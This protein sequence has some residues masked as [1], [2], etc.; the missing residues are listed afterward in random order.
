MTVYIVMYRGVIEGVFDSYEKA[1]CSKY[2]D[3]YSAEIIEEKVL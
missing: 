3:R 1:V 2:G